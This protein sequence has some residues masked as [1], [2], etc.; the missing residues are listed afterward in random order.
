MTDVSALRGYWSDTELGDT[1]YDAGIF[2]NNLTDEQ[3]KI[4]DYINRRIEESCCEVIKYKEMFR[5]AEE[6]NMKLYAEI[7]KLKGEPNE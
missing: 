4:L 2:T 1:M 6:H 3:L 5:Q 7:K